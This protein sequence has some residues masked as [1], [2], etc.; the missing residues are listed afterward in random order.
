MGLDQYAFSNPPTRDF[1][2]RKHA[3]L[4]A[5]IEMKIDQGQL[6]P[7]KPDESFNCNPVELTKDVVLEIRDRL[8]FGLMPESAGGFF[9]GHQM[10]HEQAAHYRDQDLE[11]T[12]WALH[13]M[14]HGNQVFYDCWY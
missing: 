3:M 1:Q 9:Y 6:Q 14:D 2:W 11:F 12:T 13:E 5:F 8:M 7:D 10:Q 4:Q